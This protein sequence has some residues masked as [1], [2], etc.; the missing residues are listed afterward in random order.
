MSLLIIQFPPFSN[1]FY[2]AMF[3]WIGKLWRES[4]VASGGLDT[5]S[6]EAKALIQEVFRISLS[7]LILNIA[8][9]VVL[10]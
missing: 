8:D 6:Q 5:L 1:R 10:F 2:S 4:S 9:N 7:F 3:N